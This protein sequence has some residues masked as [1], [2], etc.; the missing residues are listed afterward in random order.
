M[1]IAVIGGAGLIGGAVV[2]ALSG[3]HD[4]VTAGRRSGDARADI[5]STASLR[6]FYDTIGAVDAVVCAAG[7]AVFK[8]ISDLSD[9]DFEL[10]LSYKLMGQVNLVRIGF[11]Y[12]N[13]GGSFTLTSG[14]TAHEP[15]PGA[16]AYS[17]VNSAVDGFG[18]AAGLE[19]SPTVRVN[20]VSPPFVQEWL[21][22]VGMQGVPG[23][24]VDDVA[25]A[26]VASVEGAQTGEVIDA[27]AVA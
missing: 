4:V 25:R 7:E 6:T 23:M 2:R 19:L 13:D 22:A 18:R 26:Y 21:E 3:R 17:L 14:S 27:R 1:K 11:P 20:V 16:A 12:V 15:L 10:S 8:P 24:P 9:D 5:M